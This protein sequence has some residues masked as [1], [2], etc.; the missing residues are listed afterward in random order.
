MN[1][2]TGNNWVPPCPGGTIY[3]IRSGD[4]LSSIARRYNTTVTAIVDANPGIDEMN[5]Q[6][7]R[8]ICIPDPAPD[9]D[10]GHGH[11][12]MPDHGHGQMPDYGHDHDHDHDHGHG[13]SPTCPMGTFSYTIRYGDTYHS[14]ARRFNT[15]IRAIREAN[16]RV[17]PGQLQA[18]QRICIPEYR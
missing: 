2:S 5:L 13:P 7:G 8:K 18:G 15:T 3:T 12:Q 17:N 16:P 9:P 4:T 10:Y 6:I 14:L 11:G 1:N